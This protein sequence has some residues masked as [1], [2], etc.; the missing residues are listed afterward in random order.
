MPNWL[1]LLPTIGAFIAFILSLLCLFSGTRMNFLTGNDIFTL[2]TPI[3]NGTGLQDFYSIF[4]MSYCGG[5]LGNGMN[6]SGCSG[7][8]V[9]FTFNATQILLEDSGNSTSLERFGWPTA[10]GDDFEAFSATTQSM[11]VFYCIAAG[12]AAV[13]VLI[14]F[15]LLITQRTK[16]MIFELPILFLGFVSLSVASVIATVIALQFVNLVNSHGRESRITAEYGQQFLG[17]TWAATGLLLAGSVANL[18]F[19]LM[20]RRPGAGYVPPIE[21]DEHDEPDETH[22]PKGMED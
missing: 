3:G 13:A 17:M 18:A 9:L 5:F 15:G 1:R 20:D 16:Q 2:Y 11:G 21:H 12:I 8:D 14:R 19:V 7:Y 4:P 6:M 22:G 10:I